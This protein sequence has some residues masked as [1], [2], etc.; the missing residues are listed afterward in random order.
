MRLGPF[1]LAQS[2]DCT[3]VYAADALPNLINSEKLLR[4]N[5]AL[6]HFFCHSLSSISPEVQFPSNSLSLLSSNNRISVCCKYV[7]AKVAAPHTSPLFVGAVRLIPAGAIVL[8]WAASK[9]KPQP[10]GFMAWLTI[11]VF[12]LV[13]G[14][15][16]QVCPQGMGDN[17]VVWQCPQYLSMVK[18]N[19]LRTGQKRAPDNASGM[20]LRLYW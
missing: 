16:F 3:L 9:G 15:C 2:P 10:A 12:A 19:V 14:T 18:D 17:T 8:W 11:M 5:R 20:R 13:D 1:P 4:N 6:V 7:S